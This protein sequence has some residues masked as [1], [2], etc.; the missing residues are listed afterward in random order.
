MIAIRLQAICLPM[1]VFI[2]VD[3]CDSRTY[4]YDFESLQLGFTTPADDAVI[5][6]DQSIDLDDV[7]L[8]M[9]SGI[10]VYAIINE[11]HPHGLQ[12]TAENAREL[13]TYTGKRAENKPHEPLNE[14][15]MDDGGY[16]VW[17]R[18]L[19][20]Q[21]M[22]TEALKTFDLDGDGTMD[23]YVDWVAFDKI[24]LNF[25]SYMAEHT[26]LKRKAVNWN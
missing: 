10:S 19:S 6:D 8:N 13:W 9:Q 25:I 12:S 7:F 24:D 23:Y 3:P 20:D 11:V 1:L 15:R 26:T 4:T 2:I 21:Q 14:T 18:F 16:V 17:G 5:S 22:N